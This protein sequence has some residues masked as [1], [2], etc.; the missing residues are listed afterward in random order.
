MGQGPSPG[1]GLS[2]LNC[3]PFLFQHKGFH[4]I[5]P[6][7]SDK[8]GPGGQRG[9]GKDDVFSEQGSW[10]RKCQNTSQGTGVTGHCSV[11]AKVQQC[12]LVQPDCAILPLTLV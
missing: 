3:S 10:L 1:L 6:Q 9:E 7:T 8:P 12:I 2:S 4:I 11:D 5:H